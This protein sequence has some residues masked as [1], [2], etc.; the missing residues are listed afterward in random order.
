[1]RRSARSRVLGRAQ[2][3]AYPVLFLITQKTLEGTDGGVFSAVIRREQ[4][5]HTTA[6]LSAKA[7]YHT[8]GQASKLISGVSQHT[9]R[10][11]GYQRVAAI[12][13]IC[14]PHRREFTWELR[15][16]CRKAGGWLWT[17]AKPP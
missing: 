11:V 14:Q 2:Q 7:V 8:R 3:P 12:G 4:P 5:H 16:R 10:P 17:S 1:M 9:I 13:G 6:V 15:R